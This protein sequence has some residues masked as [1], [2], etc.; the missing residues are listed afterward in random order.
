MAASPIFNYGTSILAPSCFA[1]SATPTGSGTSSVQIN[2]GGACFVSSNPAPGGLVSGNFASFGMT[3]SGT[4]SGTFTSFY[5][6]G[7]SGSGGPNGLPLSVSLQVNGNVVASGTSALTMNLGS[8]LAG[9]TLTTWRLDITGPPTT[10]TWPGFVMGPQNQHAFCVWFGSNGSCTTTA[11][12]TSQTNPIFPTPPPA[13]APPG[14]PWTFNNF[15]SGAWG[16]PPFVDTFEYTGTGGTLFDRITLPSNRG[17]S[18]TVWTGPGF[19]NSLGTFA[20]G[21]QVDFAPGGIGAFQIRDINPFVDAAL[22]DA[23]PLQIFFEG[24]G[25]GSFTQTPIESTVPEPSTWALMLAGGAL[26]ALRGRR[27]R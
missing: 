26:L 21:S 17:P 8:A 15:P 4:G 19:T 20:A 24:G 11:A 18:F 13:N 9:Q 2:G 22:G 16:D 5:G 25:N 6:F 3:L 1:G 12:Q 27:Q 7:F 23:F 10:A 14:T